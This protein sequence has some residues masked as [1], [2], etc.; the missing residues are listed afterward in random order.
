[1]KETLSHF[2]GF[3]LPAHSNGEMEHSQGFSPGPVDGILADKYPKRKLKV[4]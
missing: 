2:C 4:L 3:F 1:M